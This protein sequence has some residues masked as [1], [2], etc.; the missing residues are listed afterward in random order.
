MYL[1]KPHVPY[2]AGSYSILVGHYVKE[3]GVP[4]YYDDDYTGDKPP[5]DL[6]PAAYLLGHDPETTFMGCL[7]PDPDKQGPSIFPE[8]SVIVDPW[9]KCP[10]IPGCDVVHYGNTR[11]EK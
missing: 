7:D 4:V 6:G 1:D 11:L 3:F 2:E 8:G 10:P 9:R 5:E